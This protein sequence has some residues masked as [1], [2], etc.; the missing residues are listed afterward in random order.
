MAEAKIIYIKN[1]Y[2]TQPAKNPPKNKSFL[3]QFK[4]LKIQKVPQISPQVKNVI[5]P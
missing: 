5:W 4:D 3:A 2:Q 1:Y